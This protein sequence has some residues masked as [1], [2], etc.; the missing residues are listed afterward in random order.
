MDAPEKRRILGAWLRAIESEDGR[1]LPPEFREMITRR[2]LD[3]HP[4]AEI[5]RGV[6]MDT[7]RNR[8]ETI[9]EL[10]PYCQRVASAVG[11]VSARIFGATGDAVR[12]YAEELGIALQLT[13]ILRDV[14]E[15]AGMDRIYIPRQD[16]KRFGVREEEI[17]KGIPSPA[18]IHLLNH[19]AE[20]ADSRFARAE[21]AWSEMSANQRRLMRAAR[22][23]SAVYRDILLQM[24]RERYD[25][26]A[27]RYRVSGLRK[28]VLLLRV[29]T[30]RN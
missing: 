9:D 17:L 22:L 26:F 27:K 28:A 6:L 12:H 20:R 16:L 1:E 13:N 18:M 7:E 23:M 3:R 14:G 15:D 21:L 10:L 11:L 25:V 2:E 19:Q 24:H 4:L 29:M 30:A 8:Y 5:V